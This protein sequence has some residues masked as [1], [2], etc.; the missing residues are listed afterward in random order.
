MLMNYQYNKL[1]QIKGNKAW[2]SLNKCVVKN[3]IVDIVSCCNVYP[4][5]PLLFNAETVFFRDCDGNHQYFWLNNTIFPNIQNIY[6]NTYYE[7]DVYRRFTL[8]VNIYVTDNV[9]Q[10]YHN[11]ENNK[12]DIGT[13]KINIITNDYMNYML[14]IAN[15]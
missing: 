12:L 15:E 14:K 4:E 10:K 5:G 8:D 7:P 11:I 9:F 13:R 3:K 6:I 2:E 1:L